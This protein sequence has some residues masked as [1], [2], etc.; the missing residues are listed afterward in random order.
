MTFEWDGEKA[1]ANWAKH[2]VSFDLAEKFEFATALEYEDRD[3]IG[4]VR[5]VAVG[6]IG[7]RVYTM[8]YTERG[9]AVRVIS[10]RYATRQEIRRYVENL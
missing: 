4:E 6:L 1:R 9:E 8:A 7:D 5:F 3:A 2:G 10:L